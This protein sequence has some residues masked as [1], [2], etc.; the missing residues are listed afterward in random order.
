MSFDEFNRLTLTEE[1][2]AT[3][4][5]SLPLQALWHDNHGDWEKA[6]QCAQAD[7]GKDG[8][9]VHAYLH[10]KEGDRENA[11]YWYAKAKQAMPAESVS[12][13]SEWSEMTRALLAR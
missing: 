4:K 7:A 3:E 5:L 10:R 11:A 6:H 12:F 13:A 8:A 9:W 2:V 1:T